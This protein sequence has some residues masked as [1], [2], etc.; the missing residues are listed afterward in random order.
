[1]LLY[2]FPFVPAISNSYPESLKLYPKAVIAPSPFPVPLNLDYS[3]LIMLLVFD[4]ILKYTL[5]SGFS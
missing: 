5:S 4:F 1:M 3:R 2:K